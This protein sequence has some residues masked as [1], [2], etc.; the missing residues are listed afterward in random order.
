MLGKIINKDFFNERPLVLLAGLAL[1]SMSVT[2]FR[3]MTTVRSQD[4]K[5]VTGYTQYGEADT[6]LLGDWYTLY[7]FVGFAVISTLAVILISSRLL[8]ID[9]YLAYLTVA[10]QHVVLIFLF[11]V[12]SA[13][14]SKFGTAA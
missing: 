2:V 14:L 13:L 8:K 12:A 4:I 5:V 11:I 9:K 7:E 1:V 3:I 10:L 6:L